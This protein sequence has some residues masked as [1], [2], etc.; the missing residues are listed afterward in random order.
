M[1]SFSNYRI[2][3][4]YEVP[5]EYCIIDF[6]AGLPCVPWKIFPDKICP[7][8]LSTIFLA[9]VSIEPLTNYSISLCPQIQYVLGLLFLRNWHCPHP[10]LSI[11]PWDAVCGITEDYCLCGHICTGLIKFHQTVSPLNLSECSYLYTLCDVFSLKN[12]SGK[13]YVFAIC[14][15]RFSIHNWIYFSR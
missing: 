7:R 13:S 5:I 3:F 11:V 15:L 14:V 2:G 6:G 1:Y 10:I 9:L 12:V 8:S 4:H